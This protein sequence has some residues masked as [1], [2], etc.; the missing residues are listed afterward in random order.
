MLSIPRVSVVIPVFNGESFINSAIASVLAQD[1][2]DLEIII[3]DDGSTDRTEQVVLESFGS[4]INKNIIYSRNDSNEERAFSRNRG[5]ELARGEYIFFLDYDDEWQSDYISEMLRLFEEKRCDITYSIQRTFIDEQGTEI[6]ISSRTM[7]QDQGELIFSSGAGYPTATA[8]RKSSFPG[9]SSEYIPREDWEI[10]IRAYLDNMNIVV[11]D[12][13]KVKIRG[14]AGR[15]SSA[16]V[17]WSST[18]RV[19]SAYRDRVP[20]QYLG[21]LLFHAGDVCLRFGDLARG[22]QLVFEALRHEPAFLL[23]IKKVSSILKR[24]FR[25]D[26]YFRLLGKRAQAGGLT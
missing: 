6:K 26:K 12:N 19:L 25:L 24:G 9:Y 17:F 3:I 1:C 16:A 15:T 22:W 18:L 14:H 21:S 8:F 13:N 4:L 7:P 20:E 11:M 2:K 5:V 23:D 10:F